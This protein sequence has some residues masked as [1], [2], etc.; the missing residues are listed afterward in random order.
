MKTAVLSAFLPFQ[1]PK[2]TFSSAD[3]VPSFEVSD[4]AHTNPEVCVVGQQ[5][6][7]FAKLGWGGLVVTIPTFET[8]LGSQCLFHN[9]VA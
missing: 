7:G 2:K 9:V 4:E 3:Q 5:E 6:E 1:R 8:D